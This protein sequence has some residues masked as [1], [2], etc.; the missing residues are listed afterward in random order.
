[1]QQRST[2]LR[3]IVEKLA[4]AAVRR[5]LGYTVT[6]DATPGVDADEVVREVSSRIA[7][8]DGASYRCRLCGKGP[9]TRR[10]LYLHIK[11]LHYD[12]VEEM[13]SEILKRKLLSR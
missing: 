3:R 6:L 2:L 13:V 1:V 5:A 4:E 10:G 8:F 11:R 9:F 7:E 12:H